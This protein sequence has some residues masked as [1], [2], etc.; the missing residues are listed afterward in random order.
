MSKPFTDAG[1]IP[2]NQAQPVIT[3][4]PV[5][6]EAPGRPSP[7]EV[8]VSVPATGTDLPVILLSHGHGESNH[9]ASMK[10]YAPVVEFWAAHGFAVIQ[11]THLDAVE[12]GLRDS[13]LAD[14]PLFWH[15][16]A[17][18]MSHVLDHLGDIEAQ[19]PGLA[20][21]RLDAGRVTAVGHSL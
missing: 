3:Y 19:V 20:A 14:A 21:R 10:G 15:D 17:T 12:L 18:D 11:P 7:L 8:K 9:L 16:R 13:D 4:H 1:N 5:T 2:V 6:V